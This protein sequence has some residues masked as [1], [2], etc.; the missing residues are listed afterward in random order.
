MKRLMGGLGG[1]GDGPDWEVEDLNLVQS[2]LARKKLVDL[3]PGD[4]IQQV[5]LGDD[6][7]SKNCDRP[8]VFVR[9]LS[10]AER[11]AYNAPEERGSIL[12]NYDAVISYFVDKRDGE[13]C[14]YL[15]DTTN[16]QHYEHP[17]EKILREIEAESLA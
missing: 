16:Y 17:A 15:A 1:M 8:V 10:E 14:L 5:K 12:R 6:Y 13:V 9:Y 3:Q 4:L 7:V 11:V 2:A